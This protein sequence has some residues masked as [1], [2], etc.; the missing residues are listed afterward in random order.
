MK[1]FIPNE[2]DFETLMASL[3]AYER[4]LAAEI[5]VK[6]V[7]SRVDL[8]NAETFEKA[9]SD[10]HND[11]A[12]MDAK[13]VLRETLDAQEKLTLLKAKL[14]EFRNFVRTHTDKVAVDELL[15]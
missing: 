1:D 10:P 11:M 3:V 12:P 7:L 8:S 9:F 6:E 15:K 13:K 14:I 4:T 2:D 5:I